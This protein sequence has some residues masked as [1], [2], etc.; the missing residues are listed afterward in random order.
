MESLSLLLSG[1]AVIYLIYNNIKTF[2]TLNI[3]QG[4]GV[5]FSFLL[6]ALIGFVAIYYGGNW[7]I[8]QIASGWL[9]MPLF[10]LIVV[11]VIGGLRYLLHK[12]FERI[13]G[14][15]FHS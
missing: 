2:E 13:S 7:L 4:I 6:T 1:V 10:I 14:G 12:L 3:R 11:I 8:G 5:G 15:V 9:R